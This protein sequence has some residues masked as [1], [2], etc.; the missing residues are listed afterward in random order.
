ME[1]EKILKDI[2]WLESDIRSLIQTYT[3]ATQLYRRWITEQNLK[4]AIQR[5][6]DYVENT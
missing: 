1:K 3:D 4:D 5:I 6:H 2:D